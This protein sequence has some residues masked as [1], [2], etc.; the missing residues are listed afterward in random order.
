[1]VEE[2]RSLLAL[3]LNDSEQIVKSKNKNLSVTRVQNFNEVRIM[4]NTNVKEKTQAQYF[5]EIIEMIHEIEGS[6]GEEGRREG[7]Q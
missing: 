2:I 1:M 3:P 5:A 7:R 4:K 6:E